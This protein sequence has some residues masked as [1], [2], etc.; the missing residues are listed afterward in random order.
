MSPFIFVYK[1]VLYQP[2]LNGLILIYGILPIADM[3]LAIIVFTVVIRFLLVPLTHKS[4]EAQKKMAIIQPK[5]KEIQDAHKDQ[6]EV[7][8]RKMME[9]YKEHKTNPYSG[10]LFALVQ[11]P[12]FLALFQIFKFSGDFSSDLYSFVPHPGAINSVFLGLIDLS[13]GS[14]WLVPFVGISQYIQTALMPL[15]QQPASDK[16]FSADFGRI[17][18]TQTKYILP[19]FIAYI[20]IQF[21]SA[22][23]L[24]WTISNIFAIFQQMIL[25][26]KKT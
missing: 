3:G 18:Q 11:I 20:S 15:P 21:P 22:L 17:M 26:R 8:A 14:I 10:C 9:L 1:T 24:H 25:D 12:V 23:A 19:V 4:L 16:S 13:K 7:Q 2:L 5:I 6:K